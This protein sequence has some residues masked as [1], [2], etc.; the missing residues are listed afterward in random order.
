[1]YRYGSLD[2]QADDPGRQR[3]HKDLPFSPKTKLPGAKDDGYGQ[4]NQDQSDTVFY[5]VAKTIDTSNL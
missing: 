3:T 5:P 4:A 2:E 1:M